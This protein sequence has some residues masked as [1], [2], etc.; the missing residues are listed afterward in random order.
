MVGSQ[1]NAIRILRETEKNLIDGVYRYSGFVTPDNNGKNGI[2]K[3]IPKLRSLD[4]LE[5]IIDSNDIRLVVLAM[6]KHEQSLL[7]KVISRLSEKDVEIKIQP[8]T[9]DILFL[10]QFWSS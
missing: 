4:N 5:K 6:E 3:L 2:H 9:L 10:Q 1:D 8:N 7:K